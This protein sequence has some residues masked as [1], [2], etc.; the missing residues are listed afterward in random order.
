MNPVKKTVL[1][2]L[3]LFFNVNFLSAQLT[4]DPA[5]IEIDSATLSGSMTVTNETEGSSE[6]FITP[7]YGYIDYRN[8]LAFTRTENCVLEKEHSIIPYLKVIP[9]KVVLGPK[10]K[11]NFRFMVRNTEKMSDGVYWGRLQINSFPAAKQIDST[12]LNAGSG[13]SI[14]LQLVTSILYAKGSVNTKLDIDDIYIARGKESPELFIDYKKSGNSPM[15]GN[16]SF[17]VRDSTGKKVYDSKDHYLTLYVNGSIKY[18]MQ[19]FDMKPG[20][21][22]IKMS[23]HNDV[24]DIPEYMKAEFE[25]FEKTMSYEIK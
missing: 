13:F 16:I 20:K 4:I 19:G 12:N 15:F 14:N 17:E 25:P 8:G 9:E 2:C 22:S 1:F 7:I 6:I 23:V 11:K 5:S 10:E 3:L 18:K 24:D 21:Y